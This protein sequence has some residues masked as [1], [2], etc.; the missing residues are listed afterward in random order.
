MDNPWIIHGSSMENENVKEKMF[1]WYSLVDRKMT[2]LGGCPGSRKIIGW[3]VLF[4]NGFSPKAVQPEAS[5]VKKKIQ[6]PIW[7]SNDHLVMRGLSKNVENHE[8]RLP[9]CHVRPNPTKVRGVCMVHAM[10]RTPPDLP[11]TIYNCENQ[12]FVKR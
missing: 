12:V 8:N 10:P 5:G 11:N 6:E 4:K 7:R 9:P 2:I 3:G 1:P